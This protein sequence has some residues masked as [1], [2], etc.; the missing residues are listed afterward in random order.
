[1]TTTLNNDLIVRELTEQGVLRLTLNDNNR[2]NALSEAM[3]DGLA[4]EFNSSTSDPSIRVIVLAANGPAFCAG[5]NL[6]EMTAAREAADGGKDYFVMLMTKCAAVM[7]SIVNC[8]KPVIAEI[9]GV[10]TAAGCQLV[11][12]CD[13][14]YASDTAKFGT[15][16]VNIG[17]FC[18]T[19]MVALSRNVSNKQAMEMLLSGDLIMAQRAV[20]IG[21]INSVTD[22]SNLT[23]HTMAIAEKIAGKSTMTVAKGKRAFYAQK[24]MELEDAYEYAC[25]VMADNMLKQDAEEGIQ[26]FIDKRRPDWIDE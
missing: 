20:E 2:R 23:A 14:A 3:L 24:E 1:M 18:S 19:P 15:P 10:A 5:H 6:K 7:Q 11:A 9:A 22:S 13:L 26:A 8:P 21:L 4:Q 25:Q 16:G 12:S 17:L